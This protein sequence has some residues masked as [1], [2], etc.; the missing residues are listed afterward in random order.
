[1]QSFLSSNRC[2]FTRN[3]IQTLFISY[4][5]SSDDIFLDPKILSLE[6]LS[7]HNNDNFIDHNHCTASFAVFYEVY[8]NL[9]AKRDVNGLQRLKEILFDAIYTT[10][11]KNPFAIII[12]AEA[13]ETSL[14]LKDPFYKRVINELSEVYDINLVYYKP[15]PI[16]HILSAWLEWGWIDKIG[17]TEW[18]HGYINKTTW[19]Q[20]ISTNGYY[21]HFPNLFDPPSW[22]GYWDSSKRFKFYLINDQVDIVKHFFGCLLFEDLLISN[23][24]INENS[25][26]L[27]V[28]WPKKFIQYYPLF[29]KFFSSDRDKYYV[30]RQLMIDKEN[31]YEGDNCFYNKVYSLTSDYFNEFHG[32][33]TKSKS[34]D[35]VKI[36]FLT[37]ELDKIFLNIEVER[38]SEIIC[39]LNDTIYFN[40]LSNLRGTHAIK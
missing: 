19:K 32:P 34:I 16:K 31:D 7:I 28:G 27:N 6:K 24:K 17:Y 4:D 33:M 15:D 8:K 37:K 12:S 5:D 18:I 13:F 2:F 29:F 35:L 1:M 10:A 23:I 22:V 39:I 20:F 36:D 26:K 38:L 30:F 11:S 9:L 3:K 21:N 25:N 14:S 40:H